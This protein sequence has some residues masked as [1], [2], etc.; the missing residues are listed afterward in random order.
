MFMIDTFLPG[1]PNSPKVLGKVY[2]ELR[3]KKAA[4]MYQVAEG[5]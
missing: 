5:V 4:K 1:I 2:I 3:W